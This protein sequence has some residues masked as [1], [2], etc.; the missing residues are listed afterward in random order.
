VHA[1]IFNNVI[2]HHPRDISPMYGINLP[3]LTID[4]PAKSNTPASTKT[5]DDNKKF[6]KLAI[7][8]FLK[9]RGTPLSALHHVYK[10]GQDIQ[11]YV[12]KDKEPSN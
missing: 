12:P 6:I 11:N 7:S 5:D 8:R 3:T 1:K 2:E 9:S 10:L 4:I